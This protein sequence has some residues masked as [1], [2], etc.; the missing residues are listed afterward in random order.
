M[1]ETSLRG[2]E[3][4]IPASADGGDRVPDLTPREAVERWINK[5]RV[6]KRESTVS[7]YH[8]RLKHFV[9]FTE[10]ERITSIGEITGWDVET[11]ETHRR[12]HGVEPISLNNEMKTL[13]RFFEYCARIELVDDDLAEKVEP[14]KLEADD[15]V[16]ESQLEPA[17]A[18]ALLEQYARTEYGSRRHALLALEWY[19]GARLGGLRGLDVENFDDQE[20]YLEFLHRPDEDTPLKNGFD[21]ERVVGLPPHVVEIVA[22]YVDENRNDV[23]DDYGRRPLLSSSVGRASRAAVRGWTYLATLPCVR[24]ECPHGADPETC[25]YTG[26]T[27]AS[28]CP[29]SRSPHEVRT[30][31]ITWQLNQ[32]IPVERVSERVNTSIRVLLRHYDKPDHLEEMRKRRQPFLDRLTF[33]D[34]G[35]NK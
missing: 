31:S 19:T 22:S 30:G 16:S 29:S 7:S 17:R 28:K 26:Y 35:G 10:A 3:I 11:Y 18:K 5:L 33:D 4:E 9:E 20:G 15:H 1:T 27:H 6:G 8:Y 23:F 2:Y 24:T 13:R 34:G 32:G 14:P 21:G 25:E 12:E